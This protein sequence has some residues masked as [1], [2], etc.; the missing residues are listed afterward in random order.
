MANGLRRLGTSRWLVLVASMWLQACAGVGYMYGSYSPVIKSRLGY[1]QKQM[2]TLGVAKDIGD[3]VGLLAG[4]FSDMMPSWG[5]ISLGGLLNLFGYG[6]LWLIV[7][8]AVYP[9]PFWM[10]CGLI[11]VGTNG[12]TFFNTA[13]L[14]SCVRNFPRN[15]GPIV[16]ILKGFT[17]L[18][19]AIFTLIFAALYVPDQSASV[20]LIAVGPAVVAFSLMY[21]IRPIGN[22]PEHDPLESHYFNWIYAI[23]LALAAYL[24]IVLLVQD[25]SEVNNFLSIIFAFGLFVFLVLPL[26]IPIHSAFARAE[27]TLS[28]E[29]AGSSKLADASE[30]LKAPLLSR[31]HTLTG[32]HSSQPQTSDAEKQTKVHDEGLLFS[33][34]EDEKLKEIPEPVRQRNLARIHSQLLKAVAEGAVKLKRRKG[35]RRGEDFTLREALLKADFWLLFFAL[36]CGAGSGLT[37]IDNLGQMGEAQG[38]SSAHIFVSMISIWN[39]LGRLGGGY[40]SEIIARDHAFPRPSM[41]AVAQLIMAVG[42]FLFAM[43]WP[44][45]LYLGSLLVGLGYGAHWSIV[46]ATASELFGLKNFG[47][48]YNFL[49]IANPL[50]SFV[51]SGLIAGSIYDREAEKQQGFHNFPA[52]VSEIE[53]NLLINSPGSHSSHCEGAACFRLTYLIMTVIC[54][55]G[56]ILSLA[57]VFRTKVVYASLYGKKQHEKN[58][59]VNDRKSGLHAASDPF[60]VNKK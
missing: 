10:I 5:L 50:G 53:T 43:A 22:S 51:F 21:V 34:M 7:S 16:G 3:S 41:M 48:L 46:P 40:I 49:T 8:S 54:L 23:C 17:G 15:R 19:G 32:M 9:L 14:V 12:E 38:Y 57:L 42:H 47:I 6:W 1:N 24:M 26:A 30:K 25:F 4:T 2:N 28:F 58:I 35:P 39:F 52:E 45:S 20:L 56:T 27:Q 29:E 33:E 31:Q 37:V 13:A 44:G 18:C 60:L 36:C 11:C 55:V 59:V